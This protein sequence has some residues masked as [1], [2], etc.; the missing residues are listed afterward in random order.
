MRSEFRIRAVRERAI[1]ILNDADLRCHLED[2]CPREAYAVIE[3]LDWVLGKLHKE[4]PDAK[5][6]RLLQSYGKA[7]P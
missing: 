7:K 2:P 3:T 4:A 6:Q 1:D 5:V